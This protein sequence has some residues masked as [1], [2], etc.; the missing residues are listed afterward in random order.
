MKIFALALL[1]L[2]SATRLRNRAALQGDGQVLVDACQAD[3]QVAGDDNTKLSF[4]EISTCLERYYGDSAQSIINSLSSQWS[5]ID[6]DDHLATAAELDAYLAAA[7]T[8]SRQLAQIAAHNGHGAHKR[9][10]PN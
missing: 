2:A 9:G 1:G 4:D 5:S 6:G 7:Q 10:R 8:T 3:E